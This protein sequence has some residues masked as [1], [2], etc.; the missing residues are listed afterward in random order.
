MNDAAK[1]TLRWLIGLPFRLLAALCLS[2]I[3]AFWRWASTA[4]FRR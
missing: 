4:F 1:S 3:P 2:G